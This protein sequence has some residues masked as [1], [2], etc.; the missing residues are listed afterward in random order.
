MLRIGRQ[1]LQRAQEHEAVDGG[2]F[3]GALGSQDQVA[4]RLHPPVVAAHAQQHL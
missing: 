3:A 1:V 4:G 2:H